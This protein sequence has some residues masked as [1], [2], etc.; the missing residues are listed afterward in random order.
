MG[1]FKNDECY[2]AFW[3]LSSSE[4]VATSY[5]LT[6]EKLI[7]SSNCSNNS[8]SKNKRLNSLWQSSKQTSK[9]DKNSNR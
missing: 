4:K 7:D 6:A 3:L 9:K 1:L 8:L 5:R 2:L